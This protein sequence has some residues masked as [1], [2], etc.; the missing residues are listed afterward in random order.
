MSNSS[1]VN[2][3]VPAYEGN[4][5]YGRQKPIRCITIHHMAG[6]LSA[7]E[8]G[9]IFQQV[10]R[11]GSSNYGVGNDGRIGLYVDECNT[12]WCNSNWDSNCESVTIE[13]SNCEYGGNWAVSDA[14]LNSL[15]RLVTDIA[16]RNNLIPLVKGKNLTWHSMFT[17]TECPGDYLRSKLDYIVEEVNKINKKVEV[18]YELI[19]RIS[20]RIIKNTYLYNINSG[21]TVK[22]FN[23]NDKIDNIIAIAIKE[24]EKYYITEY[25]YNNGIS[26]GFKVEDTELYI[27]EET[28][29]EQPKN[30]KIEEPKIESIVKENPLIKII[31]FIIKLLKSIFTNK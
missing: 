29:L 6:V 21:E 23:T 9:N 5:T 1:L 13:T 22:R 11:Y 2:V 12:S 20:I 27:E 10:G 16:K 31:N 17:N 7:E 25:S 19:E 24:N 4:F 30:D 14:A 18:K 26:N 8:C 15:I 3:H 28:P